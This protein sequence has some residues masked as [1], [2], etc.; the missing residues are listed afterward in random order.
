MRDPFSLRVPT[1]VQFGDG[2]SA[3]VGDVLPRTARRVAVLRGAKGVASQPIVTALENQGLSVHQLACAGEPSVASVN[4]AVKAFA[5]QDIDVV[6]ACG[7]GSVIDTGK[8]VAFCL[9]HDIHLTDTFS[10]VLPGPL[11]SRTSPVPFVAIPT[12][13]GTGAEV[14]S[15]A[16]LDVPSKRAKVSLRGDGLYAAH[17]L[18]DP[19]LLPSA[20]SATVL[21]SGLD[22]V[23]QTIE[24]YTSTA[25]TPFSD[26]LTAPNIR[27]GLRALKQVLE[28][29]D[30]GAWRDLAWVSLA[31]GI[32]LANSGLGAAHGVASVLGGRYG[33]PH[34]ALCGRLLLPVLRQNLSACAARSDT[35]ARLQTCMAAIDSVFPPAPGRDALSGLETWQDIQGLPRLADLGVRDEAIPSLAEHSAGASSSQKNAVPLKI[36]AYESILRSAL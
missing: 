36:G 31:S 25:A 15:N 32:A 22:A 3:Q 8:A 28:T 9:G 33:A 24:A 19:V 5:G 21:S 14:T 27:L 35:H 26:A 6:V 16:V 29:N 20:P 4:D 18:V 10:D 2:I 1:R 30:M 12:T 23:V 13:A 34:G 17:A 7:G 11:L